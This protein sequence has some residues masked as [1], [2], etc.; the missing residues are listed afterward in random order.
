MSRG[1]LVPLMLGV[2]A[3]VAFAYFALIA[4]RAGRFAEALLHR[5]YEAK[6]VSPATMT[7]RMRLL[8]IAGCA[9]S[10]AALVLA[11]MRATGLQ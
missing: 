6:G 4:W 3:L 7:A 2:L 11:V 1:V 9:V 10:G 8:G 5:G